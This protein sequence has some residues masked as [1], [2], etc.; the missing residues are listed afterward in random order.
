MTPRQKINAIILDQFKIGP[1]HDK[2]ACG[3]YE[4]FNSIDAR[5]PLSESE[6]GMLIPGMS[7][8]MAFVIGLYEQ[9]AVKKCPRPGCQT[10]EFSTLATGGRRW[11]PLP[12]SEFFNTE[13][14][15]IVPDAASGLISLGPDF[16]G[17]FDFLLRKTYLNKFVPRGSGSRMYGSSQA[18]FLVCLLEPMNLDKMLQSKLSE[19]SQRS[20]E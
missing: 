2:V 19:P 18:N 20:A 16:R 14:D 10:R 3:E 5:K 13:S 9:Q 17:H 1:G 4:L 8:T 6:P 7:I 15:L 12:Y 11:Y